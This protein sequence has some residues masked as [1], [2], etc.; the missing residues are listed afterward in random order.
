MSI[1]LNR[2]QWILTA[3]LA[4]LL[5]LVVGFVFLVRAG[6]TM[7]S[8]STEQIAA[9]AGEFESAA[10]VRLPL[11]AQN[12]YKEALPV[13]HSWSKD[14][15]LWKAQASWPTGSNP[16]EP[17]V[18]WALTFYSAMKQASGTIYVTNEYARLHRTRNVSVAPQLT[19]IED[20]L[21]DSNDA[22]ELL[23]A[24]GGEAFMTVFP[25]RTLVMT[26]HTDQPLRWQATMINEGPLGNRAAR[27][28]LALQFSAHDGRL[29]M[30]PLMDNT[31]G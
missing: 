8:D 21:L 4:I 18:A 25:H 7:N 10:P 9:S 19:D 30:T 5:A 1:Y 27:Q 14:A 17:P 22:Y 2:A 23:Y 13:A 20:W 28:I 6:Q 11:T 12:A 31:N 16:Q 24:S 26:L 15:L 3:L 29:I